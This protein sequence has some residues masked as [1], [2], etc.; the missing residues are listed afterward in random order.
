MPLAS[1]RELERVR[2]KK[3]SRHEKYF[4]S[5]RRKLF[6]LGSNAIPQHLDGTLPGDAGFD[7][8]GLSREENGGGGGGSG[9][10]AS[11]NRSGEKEEREQVVELDENWRDGAYA[12]TKLG[13]LF[14][15]ELLH[16]RWAMLAAIGCLIPE[17]LSRY[18]GFDSIAEPIWWKVGYSVL[19]DG[20]EIN[21][22]GLPGFR[23]AGDK[24]KGN[25]HS[26][27]HFFFIFFFLYFKGL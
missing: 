25:T 5:G 11:T 24:G 16:G 23:I 21:Y 1:A 3:S 8:F 6:F 27:K 2:L 10:L 26:E 14:E 15:A 4:G 22:A 7:L 9:A 18:F 20:V 12:G 17:A 13:K 19:H